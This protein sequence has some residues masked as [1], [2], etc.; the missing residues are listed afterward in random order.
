MTWIDGRLQR[1]KLG[2]VKYSKW[3]KL[4]WGYPIRR[5]RQ[6]CWKVLQEKE[7]FKIRRFRYDLRWGRAWVLDC[8]SF[9][10]LP[11]TCYAPSLVWQRQL[12]L[13]MVVRQSL[14]N[15]ICIIMTERSCIGL[16]PGAR[17]IISGHQRLCDV[18]GTIIIPQVPGDKQI[19][20]MKKSFFSPSI[21]WQT[22]EWRWLSD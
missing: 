11:C 9:Q 4:T 6:D 15:Y 22:L 3:R 19:I 2:G 1:R 12:S 5:S 10:T 17:L 8:N 18:L 16:W 21:I 14:C 13:T 20:Y 7:A